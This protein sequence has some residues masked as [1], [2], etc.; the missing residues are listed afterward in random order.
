M[1]ASWKKRNESEGGRRRDAAYR[2]TAKHKACQA[3]YEKNPN[4]KLRR[5]MRDRLRKAIKFN[6]RAGSAISDLGCSLAEFKAHIAAKF[7]DGMSWDN[8]GKYTWHLDHIKPLCSFDL[9]VREQFLQAFH[10]TNYQPLW[11]LDNHKKW[12]HH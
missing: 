3:R 5:A 10:Y 7:V 12:G 6:Y 8:W 11:A 4:Q 1:R 2:K 9:T